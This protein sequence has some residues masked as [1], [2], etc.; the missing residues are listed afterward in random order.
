MACHV[1]YRGT[2]NPH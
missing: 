2:L 1:I